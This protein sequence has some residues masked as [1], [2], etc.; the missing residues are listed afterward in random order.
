MKRVA[1]EGTRCGGSYGHASDAEGGG[2][3]TSDPPG[4]DKHF[5]FKKLFIPGDQEKQINQRIK[6]LAE[7]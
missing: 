4:V 1:R 5:P 6:M 3:N 7:H 2:W